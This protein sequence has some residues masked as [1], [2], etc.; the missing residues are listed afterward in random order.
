MD[1]IFSEPLNFENTAPTDGQ[2][3]AYSKVTCETAEQAVP[4]KPFFINKSIT[5][6]DLCMYSLAIIFL[7]AI[8]IKLAWNLSHQNPAEKL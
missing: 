6:G 5:Y 4:D 1:C 2:P 7:V 3:F 8:T